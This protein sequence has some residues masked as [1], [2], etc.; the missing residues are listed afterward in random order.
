MTAGQGAK[1]GLRFTLVR[2]AFPV[3]APSKGTIVPIDVDPLGAV[4]FDDVDF[5]W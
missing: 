3:E 5:F 4:V 2:M 1:S